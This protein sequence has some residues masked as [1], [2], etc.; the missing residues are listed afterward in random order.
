MPRTKKT[1][2]G[3]PSAPNVERVQDISRQ[4]RDAMSSQMA[5]D[6]ESAG[7]EQYYKACAIVVRDILKEKH[8]YF[9]VLCNSSAKKQVHYLSMEFMPGRSLK[10]SLF[11]LG[12]TSD[13]TAALKN[14][15]MDIEDLYEQ[16]PDAGLGNGGLGRL[17]AC[18]MDGL[19]ST[20]FQAAG[21][22]ILYEFGIFKQKIVNGW[23]TELPDHWI[24]GGEV[25]L[26]P[27]PESATEVRFGGTVNEWWDANGEHRLEHTGYTTVSA[28]P[29]DLYISGYDSSA[30]S[31]LHLYKAQSPGIDMEKFNQGD[32]VG[33]MG[34]T[35]VAE[36]ISKVLYPNDEHLE[37]KKLRLRQQ[38]FLSAAAIGNIIYRHLSLYG[39]LNNFAEKNA[40]QIN[41]THPVL[42][43]AEMMRVLL[44]NCGFDWTNAYKIV[45]ET[46]AYTNHTVMTEAL[47]CWD[48][49]LIHELLPRIYSI[50]KE[51]NERFCRELC[52]KYHCSDA[53]IARMAPVAYGK[54]RMAN[55]AVAVC[56][57]VNG[58]SSL[59]SKLITTDLFPEYY[60]VVNSKKFTN[61]TNGIASRRWLCQANPDLTNLISDCIGDGYKSDFSKIEKF[62][63]FSNDAGVLD[64][65][66]Y[67]KKKNKQRL[68]NY[69]HT[70]T[71]NALDPDAIFDIQVKRLH[72]YKRQQMNALNI[73]AQYQYIKN[74]PNAEITPRIH[75]FGAKAAPGYFLAKQ[76]IKA[77][78]AIS[79]TLDADPRIKKLLRVVYLEDYR[80]TLSELMMPAADYSQQISL[81]GTEASGTGNMKL[82]LSGA[83]TIGTMDGA[84]VEICQAAGEENELIFGM[85]ADEV[86]RLHEEGYNPESYL[87]NNEVLK[88]ALNAL[89]SGE[90]GD[91]FPE[92]YNA[93]RYTDRYMTFAD[94]T[95][96][97][98]IMQKSYD[99][100][101]DRMDFAHK[102]LINTASSG[103]FCADRAVMDYANNIWHL[104]R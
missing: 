3:K 94:F 100:Y 70:H 51:I 24:P 81:A 19:A 42:A 37:G 79:K 16:E 1:A 35:S 101:N 60:N 54:V 25:W 69:L 29:Y 48:E 26:C 104:T 20:G 74:N 34:A 13:F 61:V 38:Y 67:V 23:Q 93:L 58:V 21:Y 89:V 18:Y 15:G 71:G 8:R 50:I 5:I 31:V 52:E 59:H 103:I 72:E 55:L 33:A 49:E 28:V 95:A 12:L 36:T 83:L 2:A 22:S 53:A 56:H 27:H 102:S 96:Y 62:K 63:E 10:N 39:T 78:H 47:E 4:I 11:N 44:D 88:S 77:L 99:V 43:I 30:V 98:E 90:L 75:I 64:K 57:S 85:R 7:V 6:P 32:Y 97:R 73:I 68:S 86:A 17:A 91:T 92:L 82:M 66:L 14:M 80:V 46:F 65:L 87:E 45:C 9:S 41:D 40:I 76:I 84:N